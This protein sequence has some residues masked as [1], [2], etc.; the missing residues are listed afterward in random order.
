MRDIHAAFIGDCCIDVYREKVGLGGSVF[1]GAIHATL[2][3]AKASVVSAVGKDRFGKLFVEAFTSRKIN[4]TRLSQLPGKTSSVT[5]ELNK[6][7][8]PSY[9]N[10]QLGVLK[11]FR[12][13]PVHKAFLQRHHVAKAVFFTPFV[14]VFEEFCALK[15]QNTVKV[16]DFAGTSS[17]SRGIET[18]KQYLYGLDII[19][20]S[21]EKSDKQ[22]LQFLRRVATKYNKLCL[23]L[24]GE[25]GSIAF[26]RTEEYYQPAVKLKT[27][28][29]IGAGDVYIASFLTAYLQTGSIRDAMLRGNMA[30]TNFLVDPRP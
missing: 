19:I 3:G 24:V 5:V 6:K 27:I 15:L 4:I 30:A 13:T 1:Y 12:L 7:G 18:I 2:A 21:T 28:N 11:D 9:S 29:T 25:Q 23:A 16:G 8:V 17:Y 10:W 22:T 14:K 26:D 20:K